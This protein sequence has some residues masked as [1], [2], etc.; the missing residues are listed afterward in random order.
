MRTLSFLLLYEIKYY[1]R[2]HPT[3]KTNKYFSPGKHNFTWDGEA[4]SSG[5]YIVQMKSEN[6]NKSQTLTLIK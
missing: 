2:G 4:Y 3:E 1:K 6:Y 5:K